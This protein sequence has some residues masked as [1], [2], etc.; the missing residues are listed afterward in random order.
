[1]G[2]STQEEC[3][4]NACTSIAERGL[5]W[6]SSGNFS[7][8]LD[9]GSFLVTASG[10]Q[11]ATMKA[12]QIARCSVA[13]EEILSG[14]KP[15]VESKLHRAVYQVREDI[16]YIVHVHPFYSVLM[17]SA[18]NVNI[19]LD[20]IP[21]AEHYLGRIAFA[22]YQKAGSQELANVVRQAAK[23]HDFIVMRNHGVVA[24]G[25]DFEQIVCALEAFEFVAKLNYHAHAAGLLLKKLS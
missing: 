1:M 8:L 15:S 4:I 12:E 18:E 16:K 10:S 6:G 14:A 19:D 24:C 23:E 21:E 25:K 9:D 13:G 22:P 20:I 3:F 11:F 17:T 5:S 7:M 2:E